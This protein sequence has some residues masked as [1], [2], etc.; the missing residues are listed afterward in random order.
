[1]RC[2]MTSYQKKI[3][4]ILFLLTCYVVTMRMKLWHMLTNVYRSMLWTQIK[5]H[6]YMQ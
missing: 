4:K 3:C 1:M 2:V 5:L 6:I